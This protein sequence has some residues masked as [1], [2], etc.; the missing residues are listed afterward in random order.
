MQRSRSKTDFMQE[1]IVDMVLSYHI[2]LKIMASTNTMEDLSSLIF[3][4]I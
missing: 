2:H 3:V 4:T 1:F